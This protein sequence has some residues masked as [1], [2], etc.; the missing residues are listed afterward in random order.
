MDAWATRQNQLSKLPSNIF[1]TWSV[2]RGNA[3]F[4][5]P[6]T[7]VVV[8][9][10]RHSLPCQIGQKV[11]KSGHSAALTGYSKPTG[12]AP[13]WQT[14]QNW[15]PPNSSWRSVLSN[16]SLLPRHIDHYNHNHLSLCPANRK[17][18]KTIQSS[19]GTHRSINM[20]RMEMQVDSHGLMHS[21]GS[22]ST[23]PNEKTGEPSLSSPVTLSVLLMYL[24][25]Y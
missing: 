3:L 9:Y 10:K 24:V 25:L 13:F 8:A 15:T 6:I 20:I 21:S 2:P 1:V 12:A 5:Y 23:Y 4:E 19:C 17:E 18:A 22:A 16:M 7:K 14:C 11:L